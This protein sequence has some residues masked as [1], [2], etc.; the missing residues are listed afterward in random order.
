MIE[1]EPQKDMISERGPDFLWKQIDNLKEHIPEE[2]LERWSEISNFD[3]VNE[4]IADKDLEEA[5]TFLE[6]KIVDRWDALNNQLEA[7]SCVN[8]IDCLLDFTEYAKTVFQNGEILGTGRMAEVKYG[9]NEN[10]AYKFYKRDP[11]IPEDQKAIENDVLEEGVIQE[12]L[13]GIEISG[14]RVPK[15]I[16]YLPDWKK[17]KV[18]IMER[19][20]AVSIKDVL[21]GKGSLSKNFNFEDFFERLE[22]FIKEM[23]S[24]YNIY[25]RDLNAGNVMIDTESGLPYV[26]DFGRSI[27][28][29]NGENPWEQ[30]IPNGKILK[31]ENT[32]LDEV[33]ILKELLRQKIEY[34]NKK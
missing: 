24:K 16:C 10:I 1:N 4:D 29:Q 22:S 7:E 27:I 25:H 33:Q 5:L 18:L 14:V 11:K 15:V 19:L 30:Q 34:L 2:L 9:D 31:W 20:H 32:D 3:Y 26:I 6:K 21:M 8:I 12:Q 23:N 28:P 13:E 17:H